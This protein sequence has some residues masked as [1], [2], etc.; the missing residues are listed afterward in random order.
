MGPPNLFAT[1]PSGTKD[2]TQTP[3]NPKKWAKKRPRRDDQ[4]P[5]KDLSKQPSKEEAHKTNASS[6]PP[7]PP[8]PTNSTLVI[9]DFGDGVKSTMN[10][11]RISQN[12]FTMLD[13]EEEGE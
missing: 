5:K 13:G 1:G 4:P 3:F 6:Q 8:K 12:H 9:R 7:K 11:A 10:I 2:T